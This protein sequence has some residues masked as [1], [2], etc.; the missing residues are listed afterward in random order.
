MRD[1]H[2]DTI[3]ETKSNELIKYSVENL[4]SSP[5]ESKDISDVER[6]LYD[7][8]SPRPSKELNM[9]NSIESF[10]PSLIP[11]KD[12][13]SLMEEINVLLASDGSMPLGIDND[14]SDS[15]RD[16]LFIERL[17]Y[18]DLIS[19]LEYDHFQLN[20]EPTHPTLDSDFIHSSDFLGSN[21][22]VSSPFGDRN[23]IYDS[24]ICIEVESMRFLATLSP[25]IETL[26]PFSSKNEDRVFNHDVLASMEKSPSSSQQGFKAS[27]L[28]H[29]KS[30]MLIHGENT[31][32][33]GVHHL[34]FYPP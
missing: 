7:N 18:D 14:G 31:P 23:K 25:V 9:E 30:P 11:V 16:N 32:N 20:N 22:H 17:L 15:E 1:E 19:L 28:F 13:D 10:S 33:L 6:L 2:L 34:H 26:L 24:G 27:K 21:L 8:S 12:S 5:S 3:L 29:H 4:V